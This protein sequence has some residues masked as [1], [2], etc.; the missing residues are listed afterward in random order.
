MNE[1][2][3]YLSNTLSLSDIA[4]KLKVQNHVASQIINTGHGKNFYDFINSYRIEE[5]KN[6]SAANQTVQKIFWKLLLSADLIPNG[7]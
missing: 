4:Q 5:C 6:Y 3:I 2:K 1:E 7:F